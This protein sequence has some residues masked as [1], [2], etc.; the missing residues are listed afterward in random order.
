MTAF[1]WSTGEILWQ[2]RGHHMAQSLYADGKLIFLTEGGT[3]SI[4]RVSPKRLEVLDTHPI[5][6]AVSWSLPSLVDGKLYVRDRK[7][8]LALDLGKTDRR[9]D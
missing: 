1:N 6:E 9:A 2:E 5:T 7:H 3:L 4:A 8:I